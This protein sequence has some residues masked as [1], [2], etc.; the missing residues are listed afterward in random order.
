M[1]KVRLA[2]APEGHRPIEQAI[3]KN[4]S[5]FRCNNYKT[6]HLCII[7]VIVGVT[8]NNLSFNPESLEGLSH[9]AVRL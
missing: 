7:G 2:I 8:Y 4:K 9:S 1:N 3:Q 5:V 6:C